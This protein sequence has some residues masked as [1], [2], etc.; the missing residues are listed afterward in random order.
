MLTPKW[1]APVNVVAMTTI[2]DT[3]L[4]DITTLPSRPCYLKQVHGSNVVCADEYSIAL[5]EAD[6][7]V[8]FKAKSV[9]LIQTA[10]CLPVLICDQQGT[11]V[12]AIHAGWRG[13]AAG[14]IANTC[15]KLTA[16]P[17]QC[18]AWLGPAIGP[19]AFEVGEDVVQGFLSQGWPQEL[20]NAA[21]KPKSNA[22][23]KWLGDLYQLAR[24][25][26]Q[27]HGF[28]AD[29]IYGGEWCTYSDPARFYSYRRSKDDGRMKTLIWLQS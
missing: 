16:A 22:P 20:V 10:D 8:A 5:P 19:E 26:L 11:Q 6:A 9:C 24:F 3:K 15:H 18:L 25:T 17:Q 14:V 4:E 23:G 13:L 29:N 28:L 1:P 21:F 12:A 7:S 2:R 27:Q